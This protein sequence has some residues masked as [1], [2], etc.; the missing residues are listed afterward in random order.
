M[1]ESGTRNRRQKNGVDLWHRFLDERL[2][3]VLLSKMFPEL[4]HLSPRLNLAS[5]NCKS[6][7]LSQIGWQYYRGNG[8]KFYGIPTVLGWKYVGIP[9]GWGPVLSR[10]WGLGLREL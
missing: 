5:G 7:N 3:W 9:M 2:S 10:L 1:S 6:G 4:L 8:Y